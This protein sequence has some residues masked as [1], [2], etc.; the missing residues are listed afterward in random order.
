AASVRYKPFILGHEAPGSETMTQVVAATRQALMANGFHVVGQYV[1]FRRTTIVCATYPEMLNAAA[2]AKNGGF[3]AVERISITKVHGSW[4]VS[5]VNPDYLAVAYGLS[6]LPQ[7]DA[8]LKGA[9]GA[10][11]IFGSRRGLTRDELKPGNYHYALF[12]P[13]FNN[14]DHVRR[15]P[16]HA[17]A[18]NTIRA[19]LMK[20]V[21]TTTFVYEVN[22][23]GT[24]KPTTVFGFG[25][26]S[27]RG[28]DHHILRLID[29]HRYRGYA[30]LPYEMMVVGR[31]VIA[32]R[33]RFRIAVNFPDTAMMGSHGFMNIIS[34]P[35][36]IRKVM[37]EVAGRS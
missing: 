5:Y 12:M 19:N 26:K 10:K 16:N 35:G 1:P 4:Q 11:K 36:A 15:F 2:H 3:G 25:I 14:V 6:P 17:A 24:R 23:P 31:R 30:Y 13:Y 34:A 7:T 37:K 22:V 18:V 33:P 28:G 29:V 9:L 32:L 21:A 20:H 8:A 27:G